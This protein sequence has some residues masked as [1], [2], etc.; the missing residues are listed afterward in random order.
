MIILGSKRCFV[1]RNH[2]V[3]DFKSEL[4]V[5]G[6][7][8]KVASLPAQRSQFSF[9]AGCVSDGFFQSPFGKLRDPFLLSSGCLSA[10]INIVPGELFSCLFAVFAYFAVIMI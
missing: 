10:G 3:F 8:A 4:K 6:R 9:R 7:G 2:L 1:L 5:E